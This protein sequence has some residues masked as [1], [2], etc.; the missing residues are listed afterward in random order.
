[1][2]FKTS[3]ALASLRPG[4]EFVIRGGV[5]ELYQHADPQPTA[6]ELQAEISR[7]EAEHAAN[8]YQRNRQ[9]EYPPIEDLADALYWDSKG[10][11]TKLQEY[12]TACET[13]KARHPKPQGGQP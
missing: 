3:D 2:T 7:L 9:V 4:A 1:M 10:D 12:F 6:E 5:I 13:V 8:Q 11:S